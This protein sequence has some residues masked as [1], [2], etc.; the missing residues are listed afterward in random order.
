MD[1]LRDGNVISK[2]DDKSIL[3]NIKTPISVAKLIK[4]FKDIGIDIEEMLVGYEEIFD[5]GQV[6][7]V[8]IDDKL[9]FVYKRKKDYFIALRDNYIRA[10]NIN[11]EER[12]YLFLEDGIEIKEKLKLRFFIDMLG[13]LKSGHP[14]LLLYDLFSLYEDVNLINELNYR[15][16]IADDKIVLMLPNFRDINAS[17]KKLTIV[18]KETKEDVGYIEFD[19]SEDNFKFIG[20]VEYE[21]KEI[22]RNK[23][24]ATRALALVRKLVA[25][26]QGE[27]DKRLYITT[28]VDNLAS[29]S[30]ILNNGGILFYEGKVPKGDKVSFLNKVDY[31]KIYTIDAKSL[32]EC[33]Y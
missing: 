16:V 28:E 8:Q 30:V 32:Q 31:V 10:I 6:E 17:W 14:A 1:V 5:V 23:G 18:L 2:L 25:E 27:V 22:F 11:H 9:I 12:K 26:Y 21:I 29:Q 24:Y 15:E 13:R 19:L 20:N 4:I 3:I 33:E 7:L